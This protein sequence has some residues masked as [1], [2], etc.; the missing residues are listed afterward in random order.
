MHP[1]RRQAVAHDGGCQQANWVPDEGLH[2]LAERQGANQQQGGWE[3][4]Q[5]ILRAQPQ[6]DQPVGCQTE[7]AG[8]QG[9][10]VQETL[11]AQEQDGSSYG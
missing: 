1:Q 3:P 9:V 4:P 11:S 2:V 10:N 5:P 6:A 7:K 8:G